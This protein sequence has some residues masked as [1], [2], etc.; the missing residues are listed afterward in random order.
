MYKIDMAKIEAALPGD[1]ELVETKMGPVEIKLSDLGK[2][3]ILIAHETPGC[4][5]LVESNRLLAKEFNLLKPSRPGYFRSPL[6]SGETPEAQAD[7]FAALLDKLE[8]Q[9]VVMLGISGG[10]PSAI[11]FAIRHPGRCKALVLWAAVSEKTP[12]N[13]DPPKG[14]VIWLYHKIRIAMINDEMVERKNKEYFYPKIFP[15][16]QIEKG[17]AN[18]WRQFS[19]LRP[20]QFEK[21]SAPTLI[22]YG[23]ND[24]IVGMQHIKNVADNVPNSIL[25]P[26]ENKGHDAL[27]LDP[28]LFAQPTIEF[29]LSL[30]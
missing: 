24:L 3:I 23:S 10:G 11:Q 6:N 5:R 29:L 16:S 7:L 12:E 19:N 8:I 22:V 27:Y 2:D 26:L 28:A 21:I 17:Q 13:E 18:D 25:I 20:F 9:S 30:K 1:S 14:F 15:N 4:Y